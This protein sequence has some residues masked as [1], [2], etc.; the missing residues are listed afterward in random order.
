[1]VCSLTSPACTAATRASP[2]G[3]SGPGITRS[4]P[5]LAAGA[6]VLVANQSDMSRP[7]QPHSPLSTPLLSSS[8]SVAA[9]PFTSL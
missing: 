7:S 4:S 6:A 3:P 2:Q 9:T 8:C 5:P 1:M